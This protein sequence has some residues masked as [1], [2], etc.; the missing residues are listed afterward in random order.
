MQILVGNKV[1]EVGIY[2]ISEKQEK[3]K[4]N[5]FLQILVQMGEIEQFSTWPQ[6]RNQFLIIF[7]LVS[8]IVIVLFLIFVMLSVI[9]EFENDPSE[10]ILLLDGFFVVNEHTGLIRR[11]MILKE[12]KYLIESIRSHRI[13]LFTIL[14]TNEL[15]QKLVSPKFIIS[16]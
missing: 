15:L 10:I 16:L 6:I 8:L 12:L 7:F 13:V 9:K 2:E 14:H 3:L 11:L 4:R 1:F 5:D